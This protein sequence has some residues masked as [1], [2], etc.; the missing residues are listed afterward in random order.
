MQEHMQES[1]GY[2]QLIARR[3]EN[4]LW[5]RFAQVALGLYMLASSLQVNNVVCALLLVLCG[6]LAMKEKRHYA[7]WISALVGIWLL[8]SPV[9]FSESSNNILIGSIAIAFS[10]LIPGTPA[11]IESGPEVPHD[12]SY[13]PSSW[14][15][16]LP[17]IFYPFLVSLI[18]IR[19]PHM[20]EASIGASLFALIAL[21]G[22]KGATRRWHSMP[23]IVL[24]F[25]LFAIPFG[26]IL[27]IML[28]IQP[29][30]LSHGIIAILLL[31]TAMDAA[32]E[33]TATV[34]FLFQSRREG[35]PFFASLWHGSSAAGGHVDTRSPLAM[36]SGTR[37]IEAMH[38]G[39]T[40]PWNLVVTLCIGIWLLA[41]P[42]VLGI[43]GTVDVTNRIM[44][45]SIIAASIVSMSEV[46]RSLRYIIVLFGIFV[47]IAPWMSSDMHTLS[48]WNSTLMG[49]LLVNLSIPRGKVLERYGTLDQ[50]IK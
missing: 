19:E 26:I 9:L 16:R 30:T 36:Q 24:L 25:G 34:Q 15:Q 37:A 33:I 3:H 35:K 18:L 45:A 50:S 28:L 12:W 13:N 23:W 17:T 46:W 32:D 47:G 8:F 27:S 6:V 39:V 2:N 31:L 40:L 38:W 29:F 21:L 42:H 48:N 43:V 1:G 5:T 41:T 10:V 11:L 22:C 44:G 14:L 20:L 7:P 49:L 4:F